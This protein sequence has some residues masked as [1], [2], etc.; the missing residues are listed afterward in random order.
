M[1][2]GPQLRTERLVL[3]RWRRADLEPFSRINAD[4]R[5]MEFLPRRLAPH[6]SAALIARIET[7]FVQRGY[8]LWAL[9]IPGRAS[10]AGFVGLQPV[11][12][13][14]PFAPAVELG[15]RLARE[16]WGNGY[17]SEAAREVARFAF[18]ELQLP[19]LVSFTASVNERSRCV[20]ERLGMTRA[21]EEDFDHPQLP[22]GDRLVPHVLYR[23]D[24]PSR[25]ISSKRVR[26]LYQHSWT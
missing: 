9:E 5:V 16:H 10:L 24:A 12:A 22:V 23:L 15:W 14:L 7:G 21:A 20:M 6:E 4:G 18:A 8:G 26:P 11:E 17:A 3:R 13:P 25:R 2:A 1:V 19:S